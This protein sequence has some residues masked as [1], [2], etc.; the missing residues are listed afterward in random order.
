[1]SD[2]A[3]IIVFLKASILNE[4][5]ISNFPTNILETLYSVLFPELNFSQVHNLI[6]FRVSF[7]QK[8]TGSLAIV[9]D[10][11]TTHGW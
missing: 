8:S 7:A 10:D 2:H 1:M 9:I 5:S 4:R 11:T 6:S 3:W